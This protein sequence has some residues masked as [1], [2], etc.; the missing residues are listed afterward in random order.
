MSEQVNNE[1]VMGNAQPGGLPAGY[2]QKSRVVYIL[3]ALLPMFL[4]CGGICPLHN[5]YAGY[6]KKAL[7]MLGI[8]YGN[9]LINGFILG[10]I[11]GTFT[12]GIS[13]ILGY[14][15]GG[16]IWVGLLVW[17]I[18]DVVKVTHDANGVPMN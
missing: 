4:C 13:A 15:L 18:I 8:C 3:L 11:L 5:F 1:S 14:I 7:I 2:Q 12:L 10:F 9:W 17:C 6:T 16:A